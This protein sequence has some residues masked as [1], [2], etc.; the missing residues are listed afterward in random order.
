[1]KDIEPL[2]VGNITPAFVK[3]KPDAD[4]DLVGNNSYFILQFQLLNKSEQPLGTVSTSS[5]L[6][7][8]FFS[9]SISRARFLL[10]VRIEILKRDLLYILKNTN[11]MNGFRKFF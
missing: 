5:T 2:I 3:A 7:A 11:G 4:R 10:E 9:M 8:V 6:I 1:M